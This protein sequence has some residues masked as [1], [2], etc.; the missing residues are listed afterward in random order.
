MSLESW[1][2]I[3]KDYEGTDELLEFYPDTEEGGFSVG[4]VR[5]LYEELDDDEE[6]IYEDA[7]LIIALVDPD[8]AQDGLIWFALGS[9]AKVCVGTQ[10]MKTREALFAAEGLAD[11]P[12]SGARGIDAL[13]KLSMDEREILSLDTGDDLFIYG[14]VMAYSDTFVQLHC[15]TLNGAD[16]GICFIEKD[17]IEC[18]Q[19]QGTDER[20]V[21]QLIR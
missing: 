21:Q 2:S 20:A 10:Y 18:C 19:Y 7:S 12:E 1:E 14:I 6:E 15:Y 16:D 5:K 11:L 3:L 17:R 9:L 4:A 13:L 8:G